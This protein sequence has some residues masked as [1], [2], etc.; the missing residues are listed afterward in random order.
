MRDEREIVGESILAAAFP[1]W[2]TEATGDSESA[3]DA[4]NLAPARRRIG[5]G[6]WI[7]LQFCDDF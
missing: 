5:V 7:V 1:S 2:D 3:S 4:K 6:K